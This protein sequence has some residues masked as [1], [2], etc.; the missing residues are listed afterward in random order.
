MEQK[1]E[2]IEIE[3]LIEQIKIVLADEF[4]AKMRLN[5][6]EKMLTMRFPNGQ[7]FVVALWEER[8]SS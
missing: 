8:Q 5:K 2:K 3:N 6:E 7:K 1:S 4:V